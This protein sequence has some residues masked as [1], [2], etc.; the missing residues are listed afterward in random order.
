MEPMWTEERR[1]TLIDM[2]PAAVTNDE[3]A[4]LASKIGV[5]EKS[6]RNEAKRLRL[7]RAKRPNVG[8]PWDAD[9]DALL[10]RAVRDG[11]AKPEVFAA[12]GQQTSR[13]MRQVAARWQV[14]DAARERLVGSWTE[15]E[16]HDVREA[17]HDGLTASQAAVR[18]GREPSETAL[19]MVQLGLTDR[20]ETLTVAAA[21]KHLG[22]SPMTLASEVVHGRL[23]A[24]RPDG[25]GPLAGA[26][27]QTSV[28]RI[29]AWLIANPDRL[30]LASATP[31]FVLRVAL[32]TGLRLGKATRR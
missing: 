10:R 6:L 17:H 29:G 11:G 21:A 4:D 3:V 2:Y 5:P 26:D 31:A 32:S 1:R 20:D 25:S 27:W 24:D 15:M 9:E 8:R 30:D 7:H 19:R 16:L 18:V 12:V 14:I 23:S 22:L 28:H 13:P